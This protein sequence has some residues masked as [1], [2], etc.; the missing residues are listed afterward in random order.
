M[1][2]C[3]EYGESRGVRTLDFFFL[4]GLRLPI[5]GILQT[6]ARQITMHIATFHTEFITESDFI[7]TTFGHRPKCVTSPA[8]DIF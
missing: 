2:R 4:I 7:K 8:L 5:I 3:V 1:E 6:P